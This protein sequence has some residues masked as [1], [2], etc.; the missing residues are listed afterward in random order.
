M[1]LAHISEMYRL[2]GGDQFGDVV[3]LPQARLAILPGRR[4]SG[5][6]SA[7]AG[8]APWSQ[9]F[10]TRNCQGVHDQ[11]RNREDRFHAMYIISHRLIAPECARAGYELLATF[12]T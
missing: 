10:S 5:S 11:A 8:C 4:T 3:G 6:W 1:D 12:H 7:P 2:L 9:S